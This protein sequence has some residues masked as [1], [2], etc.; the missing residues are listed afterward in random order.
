MAWSTPRTWVTNEVVTA[1]LMNTHVRDQF[2]VL[3]G[4][5]VGNILMFAGGAP[6]WG[7]MQTSQANAAAFTFTNTS[8]LDFDAVTGGTPGT[9]VS[10]TITS[11]T[12]KLLVLYRARIRNNT[13]GKITYMGYRIFGDSSKSAGD[14]DALTYECPATANDILRAG[15]FSTVVAGI[16][17]GDSITVEL[18]ARVDGGTGTLN[19]TE[20]TVI[21]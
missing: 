17:A 20:L 2:N 5:S 12:G 6:T 21:G 1:A 18:Q 13:V 7:D 14:G 15:Y 10:V 16:T 19:N 3:D 8:F 11:A 4:G 9:A